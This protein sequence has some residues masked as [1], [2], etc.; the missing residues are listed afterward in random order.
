MKS[1]YFYNDLPYVEDFKDITNERL[2]KDAP[3]D[4]HVIVSDV[5]GST[6]AVENGKYHEVNFVAACATT[7]VLNIDKNIEF[8]FVFGGDGSTILIPPEYV[9]KAGDVLRDTQKFAK[10]NFEIDI[11]IGCVPVIDILRNRHKIKIVKLKV[12]DNYFQAV[13]HGGGLDN[14]EFLVKSEEKYQFKPKKK[15]DGKADFN[16]L[17]CVWQDIPSKKDEIVSL[18]IKANPSYDSE[19][20]IY[21]EVMRKIQQIY[22]RKDERYPIKEGSISIKSN[23]KK[24]KLETILETYQSGQNFR[25]KFIINYLKSIFDNIKNFFKKKIR[26]IS[27]KAYK[28]T[29]VNSID[30]EKFDDMLRMVIAGNADQ[31]HQLVGY[32]EEQYQNGKLAYGIHT[33]SSI[34][35]TCLIVERKGKHV[36]FI[37]GSNGGYTYAAKELKNRVKWQKIYMQTI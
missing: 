1:S 19:T 20:R 29:V 35:M 22:G 6:A 3:V 18:L 31:R 26:S 24:I 34:H 5:R 12:T 10:E 14:A 37:D 25:N 32:L 17:Q 8:P 9:D 21:N 33:T 23:Y 27:L 13:F 36:H 30:S 7:A 28:Y 2:F 16:G 4:W 11:R 15:I